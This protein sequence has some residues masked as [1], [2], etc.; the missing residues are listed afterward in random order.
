M[1]S[2]YGNDG[3]AANRLSVFFSM[4]ARCVLWHRFDATGWEVEALRSQRL[5]CDEGQLA[6]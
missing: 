3:I 6:Q 1:G 4:F 2:C 5:V